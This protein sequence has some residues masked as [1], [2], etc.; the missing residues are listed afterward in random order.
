MEKLTN[1][2]QV[3]FDKLRKEWANQEVSYLYGLIHEMNIEPTCLF[4]YTNLTPPAMCGLIAYIE[5]VSFE[6]TAAY[7]Y[8]LSEEEIA[9]IIHTFYT[10]VTPLTTTT[11]C[12]VYDEIDLYWNWEY[13]SSFPYE[14]GMPEWYREGLLDYVREMSIRHQWINA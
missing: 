14:Q 4:V 12:M 1:K 3:F 8:S 10:E 5:F 6:I 11:P 2:Q 9:E 13:H 7:N